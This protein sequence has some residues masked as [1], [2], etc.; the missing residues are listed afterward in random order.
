MFSEN[1][2]RLSD[3]IVGHHLASLRYPEKQKAQ[4]PSVADL[5]RNPYVSIALFVCLFVCVVFF[6][7][8]HILLSPCG[9]NQS[10][11]KNPHEMHGDFQRNK[12]QPK[13]EGRNI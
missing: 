5:P 2:T 7:T 6:S 12:R 4:V 10:Y 3:R 13:R 8:R 11:E 1:M 9:G